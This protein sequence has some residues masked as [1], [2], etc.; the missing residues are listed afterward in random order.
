ML[1]VSLREKLLSLPNAQK[2]QAIELLS[3]A[4]AES[5]L[6]HSEYPIYTPLGNEQAGIELREFLKEQQSNRET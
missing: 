5:M 4:L 6:G 3:S 1:E 2:Q